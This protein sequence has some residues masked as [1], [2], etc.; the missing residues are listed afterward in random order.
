MK[1]SD[2]CNCTYR[3]QELML[4]CIC[5]LEQTSADCLLKRTHADG[6]TDSMLPALF[7]KVLTFVS[8]PTCAILSANAEMY[9][10]SVIMQMPC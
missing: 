1:I 3:A 8:E 10:G 4:R 7:L 9:Q 5:L 6:V 2:A